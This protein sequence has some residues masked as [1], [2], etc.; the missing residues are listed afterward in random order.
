MITR[1]H[2]LKKMHWK[3][4]CKYNIKDRN[5][6]LVW[7]W[8]Q[9]L[10]CSFESK[11]NENFDARWMAF[12]CLCR[13]LSR[14]MVKTNQVFFSTKL[15]FRMQIQTKSRLS[16]FLQLAFFAICL[17]LFVKQCCFFFHRKTATCICNDRFWLLHCVLPCMG[18]SY[19]S[20]NKKCVLDAKC[21][22][23]S[24]NSF[25][26]KKNKRLAIFAFPRIATK[27]VY[28]ECA[29]LFFF[30]CE[31]QKIISILFGFQTAAVWHLSVTSCVSV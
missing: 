14:A 9:I 4:Q 22:G 20:W 5:E 10:L 8:R 28:T 26:E 3:L 2:P 24:L 17:R 23:N 15:F 1:L 12:F 27:G 21:V 7:E 13:L 18:S 11:K 16:L 31:Q 6:N 29:Y 19:F 25:I 30:F